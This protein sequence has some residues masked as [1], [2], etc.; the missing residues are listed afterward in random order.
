MI[1]SACCYYI[2]LHS[3]YF[4]LFT[5]A[6]TIRIHMYKNVSFYLMITTC[7][8][9][10]DYYF[11]QMHHNCSCKDQVIQLLHVPVRLWTVGKLGFYSCCMRSSCS[12]LLGDLFLLIFHF[13]CCKKKTNIKLK[14]CNQES[15]HFLK[16]YIGIVES[17]SKYFRDMFTRLKE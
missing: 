6:V 3:G 17:K 8:L 14:I 7:L 12:F 16:I 9:G 5:L 4:L 11:S 2:Y 15:S 10:M 1:W 13:L